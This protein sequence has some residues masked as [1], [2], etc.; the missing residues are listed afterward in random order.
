MSTNQAQNSPLESDSIDVIALLVMLWQNRNF[1]V[2][3]TLIFF[4]FG[5]L[6]A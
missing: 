2:K 5:V 3:T 1:I 4:V 6:I